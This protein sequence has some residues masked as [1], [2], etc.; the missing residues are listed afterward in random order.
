[1]EGWQ[2]LT[3][4][5]AATKEDDVF[6]A[7]SLTEQLKNLLL[8]GVTRTYEFRIELEKRRE[9]RAQDAK[10]AE[11]RGRKA[12]SQQARKQARAKSHLP[13]YYYDLGHSVGATVGIGG[14]DSI[15]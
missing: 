3:G 4:R 1:M 14:K 2:R 13:L 11:E 15:A 5:G 7:H 8:G 10:A 6:C 9:A 12:T